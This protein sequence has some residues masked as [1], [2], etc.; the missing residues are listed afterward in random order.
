MTVAWWLDPLPST[1]FRPNKP[2]KID[3]FLAIKPP[4]HSR[5]FDA[6]SII[7]HTHLQPAPSIPS[8]AQHGGYKRGQSC[9]PTAAGRTPTDTVRLLMPLVCCGLRHDAVDNANDDCSAKSKPSCARQCWRTD[10]Y[11][12]QD[13][14]RPAVRAGRTL[15]WCVA[16]H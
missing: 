2:S 1:Y 10:L 5:I 9:H 6:C 13:L 14:P 7:P 8:H 16:G 3:F 12:Q 15:R 11:L 4:P